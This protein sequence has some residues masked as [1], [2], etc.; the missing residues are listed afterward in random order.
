[1]KLTFIGTRGNIEA[2][3]HQHFNHTALWIGY[4]RHRVAIDCGADWLNQSL[5][6]DVDAIVVTH[7]HPDHVDGLKQGAP[8]MVFATSETWEII[9]GYPIDQRSIVR[10]HCP[11]RIGEITIEAFGVEHSLRP[12]SRVSHPGRQ[13]D[14]LLLPRHRLHPS[15]PRSAPRHFRLHRGRGD[16]LSID[17][18]PA[19]RQTVW[20][21]ASEHATVMVSLGGRT[22]SDF[23]TL[24]HRDRDRRSECSRSA[25]R[26]AKSQVPDPCRR[27]GG[28]HGNG[29]ASPGGK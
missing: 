24:W 27:R 20:P 23:H 3:T 1:M 29:L 14:S 22:S 6:W 16:N 9:G 4:R 2:R 18:S 5:H 8:C 15:S 17:G 28:R 26:R 19:R 25:S 10:S 12:R 13:C 21:R 11:F 7:G